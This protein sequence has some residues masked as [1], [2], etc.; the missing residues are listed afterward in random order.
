V[1][2]LESRVRAAA[3]VAFGVAL[4]ATLAACGGT[5]SGRSDYVRD[6]DTGAAAPATQL[7]PDAPNRPDSTAGVSERTGKRGVAGDTLANRPTAAGT[8]GAPGS[9][10]RP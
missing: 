5:K 10:N 1:T 8:G 9:S 2:R 7:T 4:S 6:A 3:A